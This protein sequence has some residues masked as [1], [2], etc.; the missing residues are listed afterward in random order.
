[1]VHEAVLLRANEML[2]DADPDGIYGLQLGNALRSQTERLRHEGDWVGVAVAQDA[3]L[4]GEGEAL[5]STL[6]HQAPPPSSWSASLPCSGSPHQQRQ[7]QAR[8]GLYTSLRA[9]GLG[10]VLQECLSA[11]AR[12]DGQQEAFTQLQCEAAWRACAQWGGQPDADTHGGIDFCEACHYEAPYHH[13]TSA[14]AFSC[15]P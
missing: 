10:Q 2:S 6:V 4:E 15:R 12:S 5:P 7:L 11:G 3:L 1:M 13:A 8:Q 14:L 9:L